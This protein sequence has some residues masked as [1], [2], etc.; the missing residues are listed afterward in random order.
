[1]DKKIK[2]GATRAAVEKEKIIKAAFVCI[3]RLE[4]LADCIEQTESGEV[5]MDRGDA[6]RLRE[7]AE[8]LRFF[9]LM[10]AVTE[11]ATEGAK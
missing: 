2:E 7:S 4:D 5:F 3:E 10:N 11:V 9:L 6:A 8:L 1:M